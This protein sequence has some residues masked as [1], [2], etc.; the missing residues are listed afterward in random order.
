MHAFGSI[1]YPTTCMIYDMFN[2]INIPSPIIKYICATY[3]QLKG[4]VSICHCEW[5]SRSEIIIID[6]KRCLSRWH[7]LAFGFPYCIQSHYHPCR[8][9][10]I[11]MQVTHFR[12][13]CLHQK[14]CHPRE[15][16]LILS[17]RLVERTTIWQAPWMVLMC[18]LTVYRKLMVPL[19]NQFC[20]QTSAKKQWT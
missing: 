8:I 14:V 2:H 16:T 20:T 13:L 19:L 1:L 12:Y 18:Y 6:S 7:S 15:L 11:F 9:Q 4:F 3:S 17:L 10:Q 5:S